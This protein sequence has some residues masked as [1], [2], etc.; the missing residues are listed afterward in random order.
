MYISIPR[1][2]VLR[3]LSPPSLLAAIPSLH[4]HERGRCGKE[5]DDL[6]NEEEEEKSNGFHFTKERKERGSH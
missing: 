1:K 5:S 4:Q 2:K 6:K 3:F